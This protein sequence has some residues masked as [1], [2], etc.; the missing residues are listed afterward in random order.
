M[1]TG[2]S[3]TTLTTANTS[4]TQIICN[5]ATEQSIRKHLVKAPFSVRVRTSFT[6][7]YYLLTHSLI[8]ALVT[9]ARLQSNRW[10]CSN[11]L[12]WPYQGR[13]YPPSIVLIRNG[14]CLAL[15]L[16]KRNNPDFS[17]MVERDIQEAPEDPTL[18]PLPPFSFPF[19]CCSVT[20]KSF[21][22]CS[23]TSTHTI[24]FLSLSSLKNVLQHLFIVTL[25]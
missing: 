10:I 2:Y 19:F 7:D 25:V 17:Q 14:D 15:H 5:Q 16:Y 20:V 6:L 23:C 1:C 18:L 3:F 21:K 24:E 22:L 12:K 13:H 9:Y 8:T 11:L 4:F